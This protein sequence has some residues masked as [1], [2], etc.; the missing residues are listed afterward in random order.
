VDQGYARVLRGAIMMWQRRQSLVLLVLAAAAPPVAAS[1]LP[2]ICATNATIGRA[3]LAAM[4]TSHPGLEAAAESAKFG[5]LGA[6]CEAVASYYMHGTSAPWLRIGPVRPGTGAV[7][8]AVDMMVDSDTFQGFPSP[9]GPVKIPRNADGGLRWDWWGPDNDDEFMNVLNRHSSFTQCLGAWNQTGNGKYAKYFDALVKDWVL[10]LPC[11]NAV[12]SSTPKDASECKPLS[13][14]KP[15]RVCQWG[16]KTLGGACATGTMES[17]WR[18]LE[19]GIR[20]ADPWPRAF[21]GFQQSADFSTD[22][23]VLLLLGISEHFK[24]LLKDGGHPGKGTVNWEM[25]QWRG[26]LS[27]AAAFP[28]VAGATQVAAAAMRYLTTFL[29]SGV[30]PDGV[31]TEM[32]SGYDMGTAGDY[33][34]SLKLNKEAG[35]P[36]P[37]AAFY[38]RVEAMYDYGAYVADSH[39]CLPM[40]GDSDLC[41]SGYTTETARFFN[42]S[43]WDYVRTGGKFG[44]APS[45]PEHETPSVMFPWAGQAVLR[46][47]WA[48]G[49]TW[50][51][52]DVGPFGS[53]AFH[54]HRDKLQLLLHANGTTLLEDSG[55][56]AY[57]GNSF[58]H[59]LR[60]Y[61]HTTQAHNT[62][63]IDGKQQSQLPA[64]ATTPR[65]NNSW[66][67]L[68][69]R[70]I[71]QGSMELYDKLQGSAKHS[72]TVYHQRGDWFL[73]VDVVSSGG[74]GG[75]PSRSV[76][77]AWHVHPNATI[78]LQPDGTAII[79]GVD[80]AKQSKPS[81]VELA[82]IPA[83][84]VSVHAWNS[85]RVVKG[86]LNGTAGATE[87]QGWFS[88]HYSDASASP[89]L[90]YD[91]ATA[92][93]QKQAVFAWL[94]L[95]SPKPF[96]RTSLGPVVSSSA[97]VDGVSAGAVSAI[98]RVGGEISRV[99]VPFE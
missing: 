50:M 58:S 49:D 13:D 91:A 54:A 23:R 65:P 84:G 32:A 35:L 68:P 76:Q 77:A 44:S 72:R 4:N 93:G 74:G 10:H 88:E 67:F 62:L 51:W 6:A 30:Y 40:N 75:A 92:P 96:P 46:S 16:A 21:F 90:V 69:E 24:G 31:E 3:V 15:G 79:G 82:M 61:C 60:P 17:P 27:A 81:G 87:D 64:V 18:S 66:S 57:S 59:S 22:A 71:V 37:P 73:V 86:Q 83:T 63:R 56:F 2:N 29:E 26:L 7:G 20:M 70:D 1:T 41:G 8:G 38:E 89:T 52:F 55:R 97:T 53:N 85:S 34:A 48:E 45:G 28:E 95:V 39:G 98:V 11:N 43:D 5:N 9:A 36:S 94:L 42:R 14:T 47:G 33:Y 80:K 25:T 19:M 12:P 99:T 78:D